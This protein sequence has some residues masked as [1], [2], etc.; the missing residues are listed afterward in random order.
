[1][2]LR[3]LSRRET[4]AGVGATLGVVGGGAA[5]REYL[6]VGPFGS[7]GSSDGGPLTACSFNVL[8]DSPD[9]EFPWEARLPR[10]ADAID[11]IGP[12]LLGLQEVLPNQRADL[13][14]AVDG[15]EWYG[16]GREGD[17]ESEAVPVAWSTDRFE[18]RD[19]GDF[20]L[21]ST[22]EEPGAGWGA[23]NPR[24]STWVSLTDAGTG[25]D[26]WFCNTHFSWADEETRVRSAELIR[27]R[28]VE[29]ADA[30]ESVVVTG[31]LNAVPSSPTHGRLTGRAD[32]Y[33]SPLAD[34]RRAADADSVR[35]PRG[36]YHSFS[37]ALEDRVDYVF[38]PREAD[39][40][41]YRTLGI[42]E[43]GYRSDH[44]PVAARVRL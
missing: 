15:Y 33:Q 1:M 4:L 8:H 7:E 21:S 35:G 31:D 26:I 30:G 11:R 22:P 18:T 10:V 32:D 40:L 23:P 39:V 14:D 5:A 44:L 29:R 38:A 34:C 37:D 6:D 16:L 43:E 12:E 17:D 2:D 36:T 20:W 28:A 27:R 9:A 25:T 42:R 24:I 3:S 13:R 19:R 41:G